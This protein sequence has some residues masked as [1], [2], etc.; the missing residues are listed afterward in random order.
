MIFTATIAVMDDDKIEVHKGAFDN[1]NDQF[2]S[3]RLP[4]YFNLF[5]HSKEKALE[6][7]EKLHEAAK[8]WKD[9]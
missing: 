1:T 2:I 3:V 7:A 9:D 8:E 4:D 6:L 5:I